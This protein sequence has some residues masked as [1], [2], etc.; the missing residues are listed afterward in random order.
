[1]QVQLEIEELCRNKT[2]DNTEEQNMGAASAV[3]DAA[4]R[5]WNLIERG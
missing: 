2:N 4:A 1:M 5:R 3:S